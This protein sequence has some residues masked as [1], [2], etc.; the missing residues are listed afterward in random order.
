MR[1]SRVHSQEILSHLRVLHDAA[2]HTQHGVDL[3]EVHARGFY[4]EERVNAAAE[5]EVVI[6]RVRAELFPV[7]DE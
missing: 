1:F 5:L 4:E 2:E 6:F 7:D 3:D